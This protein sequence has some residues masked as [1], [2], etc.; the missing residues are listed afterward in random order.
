MSNYSNLIDEFGIEKVNLVFSNSYTEISHLLSPAKIKEAFEDL[1]GDWEDDY[2]DIDVMVN[3]EEFFELLDCSKK[4]IASKAIFGEYN[5]HHEYVTLDGY[6][7]LV[8]YDESS[9]NN[10]LKEYAPNITK[11]YLVKVTNN[12][13]DIYDDIFDG[14]K[15]II[16]EYDTN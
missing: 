5:P 6:E 14:V 11:E 1:E 13:V 16:K 3:D 7:N 9:Y 12:E 8:S 4:D 2:S 10:L 15:E